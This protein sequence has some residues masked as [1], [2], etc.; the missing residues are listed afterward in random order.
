M[1]NPSE[2]TAPAIDF[3]TFV[4]SLASSA[5]MHMGEMERPQGEQD[6]SA[7]L[8]LARQTIDILGM[9]SDKTRGNLSDDEAKLLQHLLFDLRLKFVEA[10]QV[11]S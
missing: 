11:K 9:L 2:P 3:A 6:A 1:S 10:R 4:M 5:L 8:A 7:S